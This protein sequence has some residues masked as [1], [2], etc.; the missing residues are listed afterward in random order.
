MIF[1]N[2][3]FPLGVNGFQENMMCCDNKIYVAVFF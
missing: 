1:C 3:L 2:N